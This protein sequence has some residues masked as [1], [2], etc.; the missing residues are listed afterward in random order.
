MF[1][2]QTNIKSLSEDVEDD[3]IPPIYY[4]TSLYVQTSKNKSTLSDKNKKYTTLF[5]KKIFDYNANN[6]FLNKDNHEKIKKRDLQ[7]IIS[8]SKNE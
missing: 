5:S 8:D 4:N 6:K 3:N 1:E 2:V 7:V